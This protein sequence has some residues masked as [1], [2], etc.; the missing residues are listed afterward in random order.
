MVSPCGSL[1]VGFRDRRETPDVGEHDGHLALLAAEH[2]FLR[3]LRELLDQRR[4]QILSERGT[5]LPP[6][7]LLPDEAGEDQGQ[8]DRRGRQQRIGEIDQQPV[9]RIEIPGRSDQQRREQ[10]ADGAKGDRAEHRR[11]DDHQ[12]SEDQRGKK[13]QRDAVTRL[14]EHRAG[15]RALEHL[16]VDFNARHRRRNRRGLDVVKPH[17]RGSDQ[18]QLAA[19]LFGRDVSF[20]QVLRRNIDRGIAASEMDP[21]LAVGIRRNLETLDADALDSGLIGFDENGVG[22][23]DHP[24]EFKTQRRHRHALGQ[25]DHRHPPHNA[26]A[27]GP[28]GEQSR[29]RRPPFP[30]PAC[31]EAGQ[32]TGA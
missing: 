20:E 19:D 31:C 28:D 17:R 26:V 30:E 4:R 27:F 1:L 15:Q 6:L 23:G 25:Q 18:H 16:G 3:R 11:E 5:D 29:A 10:G 24:Q 2:E 7:R 21:E 9:L 13:F 32:E 12:D 8:I 14:R 22:T